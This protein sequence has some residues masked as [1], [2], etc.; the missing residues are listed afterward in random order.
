MTENVNAGYDQIVSAGTVHLQLRRERFYSRVAV[1]KP[2]ITKAN[3]H[4]HLSG[5]ETTGTGLQRCGKS[6]L[7]R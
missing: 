2:L 6:D 7:V 5:P 4:F 1:H 3:E